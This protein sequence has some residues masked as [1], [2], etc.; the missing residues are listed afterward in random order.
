MLAVGISLT[1]DLSSDVRAYLAEIGNPA[2]K[3]LLVTTNLGTGLT[4]RS[5]GDLTALTHQLRDRMRSA[6]GRRPT[7]VL[8][9][10]VGP[11]AGAAFIGAS[12][13]AVAREIQV[14]EDQNPGYRPGFGSRVGGRGAEISGPGPPKVT[15]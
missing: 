14:Y 3:L 10:Y 15:L 2:A 4:I 7:R 11:L 5:A 8:L 1:G 13:N 9:F 6:L 12:L